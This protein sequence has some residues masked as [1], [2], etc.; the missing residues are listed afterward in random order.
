[1]VH[2]PECNRL[3]MTAIISSRDAVACVRKYLVE[4]SMARG[5]KFFIVI[6][7]M[8]IIS[9]LNPIQASSQ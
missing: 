9:I 6:G 8:A 5:L 3:M 4:A 2:W 7:M 1:M